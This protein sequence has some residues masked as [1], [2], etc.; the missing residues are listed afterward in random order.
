MKNNMKNDL[1]SKVIIS[2]MKK[3]PFIL[4]LIFSIFLLSNV[5]T[6]SQIDKINSYLRMIAEGKINDVKQKIPELIA[7][8]PN[9]PGVLLLQGAVLEDASKA[10]PYYK[11]ILEKYPNSEWAANAAW[12][13]IQY[14]SIVS[15]T[16]TAKKSL[17]N[18][19]E[20]YPNSPFLTPAAEAVR[21]SISD[22]KYENRKNYLEPEKKDI[23][24]AEKVTEK[25][26]SENISNEKK[27]KYGL[28]VGIYSTLA[29]AET[30]RER[31]IKT[32]KLRTEVL[33][34]LVV[35]E[36]KYAVVIGNYDSEEEAISAKK[37]VEK[38]C[39]CKSLV[40]KK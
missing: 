10:I 30:E 34:K 21:F 36:R 31:F 13:M 37:I 20:K 39:N 25:V 27:A 29:A 19:R 3:A 4:T 26:K 17:D 22:A 35:G 6:F 16:A 14:Y 9:E 32:A 38:Q 5:A 8:Y 23:K 28:Q 7:N 15:D 24:I 1:I 11:K 40:Y 18:F 12:R 33:E 2:K